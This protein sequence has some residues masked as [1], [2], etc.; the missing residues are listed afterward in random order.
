MV[1]HPAPESERLARLCLIRSENVGPVTFRQLL[2]HFKSAEEA[3]RA[4][5]EL[6]RRGGRR[7]AIVIASRASGEREMAALAKA[8]GQMIL[9]GDP[10]YPRLLATLPDAPAVLSLI[11]HPALLRNPA[12]AMVGARNG[13]ANGMRL[14]ESLATGLS[15]AGFCVVSGMARGI[16]AA[17]HRGALRADTPLP[18]AARTGSA[19]G[20]IAV[21]AG[22]VDVLYPRDN[23]ALFETLRGQGLILSEQ[24]LG[25]RPQ[26]RHFPTRNRLISGLALATVVV[27]ATLRSGS[28]IT[29]RL[30]GEQGRE[31][32]AIPGN[33]LDPRARGTNR[34][35]RD[36]AL[37][38]ENADDVIEGLPSGYG[39]FLSEPDLRADTL[40][41]F[42]DFH[43]EAKTG[44]VES[45]TTE[46]DRKALLTALG[47]APS[48]LDEVLRQ[49]G[50]PGP[51]A[52]LILLELELAGRLHR[53]PGGQVSL[54]FED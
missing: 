20:T 14:A 33:P 15:R 29:A 37:L 22:G 53:H 44:A 31:V 36:G 5:P 32:M 27:E 51:R 10:D 3:L 46:S 6:A 1:L 38:V 41:L 11:G 40:P 18:D 28:L 30:A 48:S 26:A 54:A 4:L 52:S 49:S 47:A 23:A 21:M 43:R 35:I 9:W 16:D 34:L 24:P 19:G 8:G 7:K 2:A 50:V 13:S 25:L 42:G 45:E 12:I 39:Q 17:A